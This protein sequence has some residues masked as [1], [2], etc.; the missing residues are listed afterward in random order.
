MRLL[1]RKL[2]GEAGQALPMALVLL[3]LGG[4]LVVPML[5]FMTT[6]LHA[7]RTVDVKTSAI[8]AADSGIQDALWKLG[9]GVDPFASGDSYDLTENVNM[10]TVTV[11]KQALEQVAD[12]DLYTLKA[13]ARLNGEVKAVIIAQAV[14]GSD[15]SWLFKHALN[16]AQDINL[17]PG[18]VIYGVLCAEVISPAIQTT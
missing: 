16:S 11:E 1:K 7:N 15:F 10:M 4:L 14:S 13:T 8:Y 3:V 5:S 12:G 2:K 17:Q 6:S 9:N 18:N